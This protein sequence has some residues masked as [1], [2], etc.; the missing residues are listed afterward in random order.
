MF[1]VR[2]LPPVLMPTT[3]RPILQAEVIEGDYLAWYDAQDKEKPFEIIAK[4][5]R[6]RRSK[7]ANAYFH[8]LC[9][10]I[11]DRLG[12]SKTEVKNRMIALYG[13]PEIIDGALDFVIVRA[14]KPVEKFAEIHL[15]P[16]AQTKELNGKLYRVYINMRHTGR[17]DRDDGYSTEEMSK[18]IDGTISEAREIGMTD[19][20]IVSRNDAK[21]LE[22]YGVKL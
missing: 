17:N 1:K 12:T 16:T 22:L 19:A 8:V 4:V 18:L 6:L 11:A 3:K 5:F 15:Q 20:E 14:D 7:D 9:G 2:L 10:K 21:M 13:Q